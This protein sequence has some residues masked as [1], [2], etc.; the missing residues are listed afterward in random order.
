LQLKQQIETQVAQ[1]LAAAG[2]QDNIKLQ[3]LR[4]ELLDTSFAAVATKEST[5]Q[6]TK[7]NGGDL[8]W[9]PRVGGGRVTET[10]AKEA[11]ALKPWEMS[12]P[13]ATE[14]GY[15]LILCVDYKAG[16]EPKFETIREVVRDVYAG[17]MREAIVARM[18]PA[19]KIDINP[20][21]K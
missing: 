21:P 16:A 7:G 1:Q 19:A 14:Y 2:N 8:G 17:K 11:F 4:M 12:G 10:F 18:K 6:Q 3:K 9:F 20:A 13:V 5:D 15:H